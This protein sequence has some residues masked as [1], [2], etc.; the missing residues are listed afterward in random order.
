MAKKS[1]PVLEKSGVN[2]LLQ[3]LV[4][5]LVMSG[6]LFISAGR[7]DW[8]PAWAY[9]GSWV[10]LLLSELVWMVFVNPN[11]IAVVNARGK[12]P[13]NVKPWDKLIIT[14]YFPL[15]FL[16][17]IVGGL[18]AGRFGW[19]YMPFIVQVL[20]FVMT[21]VSYLVPVW[22]IAQN[23]P[24]LT[25]QVG[26]KRGQKICST[27]PYK[28]IRHPMYAGMILG[29]IGNPLLLGSYLAFIPGFL[30]F[31]LF[32]TRT[33]LEDRDLQKE[34]PGYRAYARKTRYKLL[35]GIW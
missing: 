18:D 5:A 24:S 12:T 3:I 9:L 16:M 22:A 30:M 35:P 1:R 15:P 6:L 28:Y 8:W 26:I 32:F 13:T 20:G 2:R 33:E 25:T 4:V 19:S 34:L 11:L 27:G 31:V 23:V 21:I 7:L 17:M 29:F 14:L 10:L